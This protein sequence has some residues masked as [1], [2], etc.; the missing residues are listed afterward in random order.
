MTN[1]RLT[2]TFDRI[3]HLEIG[4]LKPPSWELRPLSEQNVSELMRSIQSMGLLQPIV[5]RPA[6]SGYQVVFGNHRIEACRRLGMSTIA[7]MVNCFSD[8][9]SFLARVTENLLRN[10]HMNPIEEARGYKMLIERGWTI[11]AIAKKV[12]KCDSY[13]CERLTMLENL[14]ARLKEQVS[15]GSRYFTPSHAEL[16]S[17]LPDKHQQMEVAKLIE[18]KRLSVRMVE[19]LLNGVPL[20]TTV[21]VE[22]DS[23]CCR[24]RI[25]D[26][27]AQVLGLKA[28][29]P[30]HMHIRGRKLILEPTRKRRDARMKPAVVGPANTGILAKLT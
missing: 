17:R 5:V 18:T 8:E 1:E 28:G 27:Y 4:S 15:K 16:L 21:R 9:E 23:G 11:N 20:P 25:P 29:E 3:V 10:V 6:Q 2:A 24:I 7:A 19:G 14:N 12:G 22:T 26:E 13:V 30:I